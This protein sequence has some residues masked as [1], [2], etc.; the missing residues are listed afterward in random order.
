M[1]AKRSLFLL[2]VLVALIALSDTSA[3]AQKTSQEK[4]FFPL[5][6]V[7]AGLKGVSRTVF[8]GS[9][10]EEFGV[11]VLGV[12]PGFPAPRQSAI[13]ARLTGKNVERTGVFGGMSGSP[14][15]IDGRLVGAIAFCFSVFQRT[16]RRHYAHQ[17]DD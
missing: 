1:I 6:E 4:L 5:E 8:S 9:E 2:S 11:E 13:I 14:V 7:R 3:L 17:A 10:P 12:L 15:Y 16:Y